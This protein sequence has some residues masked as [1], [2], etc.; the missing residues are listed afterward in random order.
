LKAPAAA[1][2]SLRR[3]L[4][5]WALACAAVLVLGNAELR[6]AALT[7]VERAAELAGL[8]LQQVTIAGH[9][10]TA[11]TEIYAA[12]NLGEA[13]TLLSFDARAAQA[14]LEQL[15]WVARA[16]IE[17]L[18]PDGIDVSITER[19]PFAVWRSGDRN[20]L[21]DRA[22]RKLQLAPA[23]VMPQ[24]PR[25]AGEGAG[26][27]AAAL[28]ALLGDFPRI[29]GKLAVAERV[30]GR[31]WTLHLADGASID[32][33]AVDEADALARLDRLLELG[34]GGAR[35]IDLRVPSRLLVRGLD[36]GTAER[37]PA[38]PARRT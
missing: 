6:A 15:P 3:R 28:S 12:L 13:R 29:A 33:P 22:G 32:L 2:R 20:W 4:G 31:R 11:D 24:L 9:R 16:S 36:A 8:G 37:S 14:R 25:V 27:E 26:K 10:F 7:Q 5:A 21:I 23:D 17:R 35:H 1:S 30:G 19:T 38:A 18:V 34:L